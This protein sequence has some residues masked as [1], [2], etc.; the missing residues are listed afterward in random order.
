MI[1]PK[2]GPSRIGTPISPNARPTRR[3]PALCA[4]SVNPTGTSIPPPRPCR[5]RNAISSPAEVASAHSAEPTANSAIEAIQVG[6]DPKRSVTQPEIGI[7]AA[8]DSR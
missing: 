5:T 6:F 2:M 1:G 7:T 3:G 4:T 8:S